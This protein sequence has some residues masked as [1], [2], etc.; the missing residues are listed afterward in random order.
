M[1]AVALLFLT[2]GYV[3]EPFDHYALE[4]HHGFRVYV[5]YAARKVNDT[6]QPALDLLDRQLK[7]VT[8]IVPK[9][10]LKTLREVPFFIEEQNPGNPCACYHVS[11]DWLKANGYI[12]EKVRSVEISNTKNYVEWVHLNQ[13]YMTLHEL[14]HGFHDI[15]FTHNDKYIGAVYRKAV[16]SAKYDMVAHNRGEKRRA[17]ALNN[18]AEYFAELSEAY[19]GEN[20]FFPFRRDELKAFDPDG[21]EMIE[22]TWGVKPSR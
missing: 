19:F 17:Y 21:F 15:R 13:P 8:E 11:A 4:R 20:D 22:K 6:T 1:T 2:Q 9:D 12:P 10:A 16:A 14:A 7:K 18:Q 3:H 5:S